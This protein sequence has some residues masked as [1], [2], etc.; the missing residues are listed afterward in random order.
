MANEQKA[1][2]AD[3]KKPVRK[4]MWV[5]APH[6]AAPGEKQGPA[7]FDARITRC[8]TKKEVRAA[9]AKLHVDVTTIADL[10]VFV[11]RSD[12]IPPKLTT[13]VIIKF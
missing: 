7:E 2:A 8:S 5:I 11:L 1:A 4:P 6:A 13:Q 3:R 10:G 12:Q 9:L